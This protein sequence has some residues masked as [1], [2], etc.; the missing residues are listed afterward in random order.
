MTM[1][2]RFL[3][4]VGLRQ[5]CLGTRQDNRTRE[6]AMALEPAGLSR[7]QKRFFQILADTPG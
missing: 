3:K 5:E 1:L 4:G 7:L 6:M 2:K